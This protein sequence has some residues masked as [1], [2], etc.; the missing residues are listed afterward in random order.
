MSNEQ[1]SELVPPIKPLPGDC[2][3]NGCSPCVWDIYYEELE[4]FEAEKA[5]RQANQVK[6]STLSNEELQEK[7]SISKEQ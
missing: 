6:I 3:G 2:C 5:K 7:K 1:E 4:R